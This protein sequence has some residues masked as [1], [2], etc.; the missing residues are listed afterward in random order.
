MS[1]A[2]LVRLQLAFKSKSVFSYSDAFC[3]CVCVC[4]FLVDNQQ[5]ANCLDDLCPSQDALC[6]PSPNPNYFP[7]LALQT[8]PLISGTW[9]TLSLTI[10]PLPKSTRQVFFL[11]ISYVFCP[12]LKF[13]YQLRIV[14]PLQVFSFIC[15]L[16]QYQKVR[17]QGSLTLQFHF[18]IFLLHTCYLLLYVSFLPSL[19]S[20]SYNLFIV[21]CH[22]RNSLI[23]TEY[24]PYFIW[25]F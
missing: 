16:L 5:N 13:I 6:F 1:L 10:F 11:N 4:V 15:H 20:I 8:F 7:F 19:L 21:H 18:F 24:L 9:P 12:E 3:V 25:F 14:L 17:L 2:W 23:F 22:L